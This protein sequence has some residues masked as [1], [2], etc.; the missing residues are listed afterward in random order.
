MDTKCDILIKNHE[1]NTKNTRVV[2]KNQFDKEE[3]NL[4]I[5]NTLGTKSP[6]FY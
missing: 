1:K 2:N 4:N 5:N 6:H 3:K